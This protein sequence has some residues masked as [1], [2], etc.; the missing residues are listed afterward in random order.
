MASQWGFFKN[1]ILS[2]IL[3]KGAG[4]H[5]L[6]SLPLISTT[7]LKHYAKS[8]N[9]KSSTENKVILFIDEFSSW[10]EAEIAKDCIDGFTK[11]RLFSSVIFR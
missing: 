1:K 10:L 7:K 2:S 6:R 9:N 11:V 3:K 4:I 8:A 5:P